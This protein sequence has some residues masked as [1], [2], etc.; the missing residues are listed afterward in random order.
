MKRENLKPNEVS[1]T[2]FVG[3]GGIG[4]KIIKGVA[5][6]SIHDNTENVRFVVLDTDVNDLI[7]LESGAVVST[8]QTSSPRSIKD[9]LGNDQHAKKHWFP[10]NRI[11]DDKTVSEGAGQIRAISRLA[12]NATVKQGNISTLYKAID[13]LYLKD[14]SDK[15]QAMKIVIASTAAGGT[16]SGIAMIVG[17]LVRQYIR[18]NYPESAAIIRGLLLLP[19]VMDTVIDTESERESLRRN[20]YATIKEINAF[21][22]KGSGFFDSVPDLKRYRDLHIAVPTTAAGND[23]L[24]CLP[25][26]FCF[27][28][29]RADSN[30]GSMQTLTQYIDSAAQSLSMY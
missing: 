27:L 13:E 17:M 15:K 29:D 21:M 20:G 1:A 12:I 6:R 22:M 26:D 8:V 14:G 28:M 23:R 5:N 9:Y 25:F 7:R 16:G 18:K 4:S 3:V 2:L 10:E 11:L 24:E 19:S 30:Q